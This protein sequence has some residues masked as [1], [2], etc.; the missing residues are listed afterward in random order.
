[1][2]QIGEA[3]IL[4][5]PQ[6]R[7]LAGQSQ[8]NQTRA[9]NA[10]TLYLAFD[11]VGQ[12]RMLGSFAALG[13]DSP[14]ATKDIVMIQTTQCPDSCNALAGISGDRGIRVLRGNGEKCSSSYTRSL[15]PRSRQIADA[16]IGG[17][18]GRR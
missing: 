10:I 12:E 8:V 9:S 1:M 3:A 17:Q 15:A 14:G 4:A 18:H 5:R 13:V 11:P 2:R 6:W 7:P 16:S